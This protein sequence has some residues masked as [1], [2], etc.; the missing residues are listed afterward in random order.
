MKST[1][2]LPTILFACFAMAIPSFAQKAPQKATKTF[3]SEKMIKELNLTP[4]Q[5]TKLASFQKEWN[6]AKK[7]E[8]AKITEASKG[9][10]SIRQAR[11]EEASKRQEAHQA[12][13]KKILTPEQYTKYLELKVARKGKPQPK[14]MK[15]GQK[16]M[17]RK[18]KQ[19]TKTMP[20]TTVEQK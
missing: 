5:Q 12:E 10:D 3:P 11:R 17:Q 14:G 6:E 16:K 8:R 20:S 9:N 18:G 19:A 15:G 13:I 2:K 4:E 1:R 7:T